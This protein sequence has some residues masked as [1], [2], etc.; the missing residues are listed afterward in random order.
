MLLSQLQESIRTYL[1]TNA[2]KA[3]GK[4]FFD[5]LDNI[6]RLALSSEQKTEQNSGA[7]N[8]NLVN[9]A[10]AYF[11][12]KQKPNISNSHRRRIFAESA[13]YLNNIKAITLI[14]EIYIKQVNFYKSNSWTR[15]NLT[16]VFIELVK[17]KPSNEELKARIDIYNKQVDLFKS[18]SWSIGGLTNAFIEL[19]KAKPSIE[20]WEI[21]NKQVDLWIL[22]G[23]NTQALTEAFIELV[24]TKPTGKEL[25]ARTI[26]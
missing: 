23:W 9:I 22:Q 4:K 6:F 5:G 21:Y 3:K 15:K 26:L 8:Q 19:I 14:Q 12:L 2:S 11:D 24:K 17:T 18:K 1:V 20:E 16:E 7:V 13:A 25:V 10:K